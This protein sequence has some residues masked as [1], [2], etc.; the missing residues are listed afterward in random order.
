M[1]SA[2]RIE[3]LRRLTGVEPDRDAMLREA[4]TLGARMDGEEMERRAMAAMEGALFKGDVAQ[5][6]VFE[7]TF[8]TRFRIHGER[9]QAFYL[10]LFSQTNNVD[11]KGRREVY[12]FVVGRG[13]ERPHASLIRFRY[14]ELLG[15]GLAEAVLAFKGLV[16][17]PPEEEQ[18][19]LA[20]ERLFD[21]FVLGG[22]DDSDLR[23]IHELWEVLN[24]PPRFSEDRAEKMFEACVRGTNP[25]KTS[26]IAWETGFPFSEELAQRLILDDPSF[27]GSLGVP[28]SDTLLDRHFSS[29][30]HNELVAETSRIL[31]AFSRED[32]FERIAGQL[33]HPDIP[34]PE[35]RRAIAALGAIGEK[36][37]L[38][39]RYA[40]EDDG[41]YG[42]ESEQNHKE[43]Y[44]AARDRLF[45]LA[46]RDDVG[47][48][49]DT[50]VDALVR[51][52]DS[53]FDAGTEI[54]ERM[55]KFVV[56]PDGSGNVRYVPFQVL[57]RFSHPVGTSRLLSLLRLK[58][59]DA[60]PK[61][62]VMQS[63]LDR[64]GVLPKNVAAW[65]RGRFGQSE[66]AFNFDNLR[67][68][69]RVNRVFGESFQRALLR[70]VDLG[71]GDA[72]EWNL[73]PSRLHA[74]FPKIPDEAFI[75]AWRLARSS[76]GMLGR[77]NDLF[78]AISSSSA[79]EALLFGIVKALDA[80]P[81]SLRS[82]V[83]ALRGK[84]LMPDGKTDLLTK[85]LQLFAAL[86]RIERQ[87][88]DSSDKDET[89][90]FSVLFLMRHD[91][92]EDMY[93]L[94]VD[95][96]SEVTRRAFDGTSVEGRVVASLIERW[97]TID[98]LLTYVGNIRA[99]TET[100]RYLG[101]MIGHMDP[102]KPLEWQRWRY[103]RENP[104][105]QK[106]IGHLSPAQTEHWKSNPFSEIGDIQLALT[107]SDRPDMI[108]SGLR[109]S[110]RHGHITG[111]NG[112]AHG[113]VHA[114]LSE[115]FARAEGDAEHGE[116]IIAKGA[117]DVRN[118]AALVDA[119][120][121]EQDIRKIAT[122]LALFPEGK[123]VE[124]SSKT[125]QAAE[126]LCGY[127]PTAQ[128][129]SIRARLAKEEKPTIEFSAEARAALRAKADEI[130]RNATEARRH[131]MRLA[132]YGLA[133]DSF[134]NM[135]TLFKKRAE[136]KAL[137]DILRLCVLRP[138]NIAMN[139]FPAG[140]GKKG[141]E[142]LEAVKSLKAYFKDQPAFLQD[143]ENV[144]TV[145]ASVPDIGRTRRLALFVTDDPFLL[146]HTGK[147]PTGNGSCQNFELNSGYNRTLPAYVGDAHIKVAFLVDI[148]K[149]PDADRI[150]VDA[151]GF[152]DAARSIPP[153]AL[154][155]AI[156][157]RSVL[158]L[159]RVGKDENPAI[160][161]EPIYSLV[162]KGDQSMKNI[163]EE[164]IARE[165]ASPMGIRVMH[166]NG[167]ESVLVPS[168][169]NPEGQYEDGATGGAQNAG[170][171]IQT[172]SYRMAASFVETIH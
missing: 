106:Q 63:L 103:D 170:L 22:D 137:Q 148:G 88:K 8:G 67:Y 33:D 51:V 29:I 95:R 169:K 146:F 131:E 62:L 17:V 94:L 39:L 130:L 3:M 155:E 149:L 83:E 50:L 86:D 21:K 154:L 138:A 97:G 69:E 139:R 123:P 92:L 4:D 35:K 121:R 20:Y 30:G 142:I 64:E 140:Q 80:R 68:V 161:V 54:A 23:T 32:Y 110:V 78:G 76:D 42:E 117:S 164:W 65:V 145:L 168:S 163:F 153:A 74:E 77:L 56:P 136:M 101:E 55:A 120:I 12:R 84:D 109:E 172:G 26:V 61:R 166:G 37:A 10:K 47:E 104:V 57:L 34:T 132:A 73:E 49:A 2:Q 7:R 1:E 27:Q 162:N 89:D 111:E 43:R 144:E 75:P 45:A 100:I 129:E 167:S 11:T 14:A 147:Y 87:Q 48:V 60:E 151:S 16:G 46:E 99:Y 85:I 96:A 59:I 124:V 52:A 15:S 118:D 71:F 91:P 31:R 108:R 159:V 114:Q 38:Q 102:S 126:F 90:L 28:V 72:E 152:K 24:V 93:G 70:Q 18:V 113:L 158:K 143:L 150:A 105:V 58:R 40:G 141:E 9:L 53:Y 79:R 98:P 127:L 13:N 171:G 6:A 157:G 116:E 82:L 112:L 36:Y 135:G 19:Q 41:E 119:L 160:F 25:E 66:T 165:I 81:K 134:G 44:E 5:A 156:V 128:A 133:A 125:R 115:I 107:P 122:G